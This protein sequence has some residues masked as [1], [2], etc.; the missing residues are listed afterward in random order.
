VLLGFKLRES[1]RA[2]LFCALFPDVDTDQMGANL[3]ETTASAVS[4]R[5]QSSESGVQS[6]R[7]GARAKF[8][9]AMLLK[10]K[11]KRIPVLRACAA[12]HSKAFDFICVHLRS[13]AFFSSKFFTLK[14]TASKHPQL[15]KIIHQWHLNFIH[16]IFGSAV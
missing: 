10:F 7:V 4:K 5:G 1:G 2:L 13:F 11:R 6:P 14:N 3:Y 9:T 15:L 16:Q 12:L 8:T